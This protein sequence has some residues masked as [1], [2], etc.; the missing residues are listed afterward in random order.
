MT[1][2]LRKKLKIWRNQCEGILREGRLDGVSMDAVVLPPFPEECL[3][4]EC[5]AKTR[6]GAACKIRHVYLNGR[7]KFH[8]GL[9][10][11]PKTLDGKRR[12]ALNTGK[13]YEQLLQER[14]S[15]SEAD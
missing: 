5:G 14:W 7:C 1:E 2:D 8:G 10:T 3:N 11:G 15:F 4:M 6:K 13:T 9:S 12:S